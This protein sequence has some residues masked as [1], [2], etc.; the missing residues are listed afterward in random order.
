MG[1]I[2]VTPN[3]LEFGNSNISPICHK[4]QEGRKIFADYRYST[5]KVD[6]YGITIYYNND[7]MQWWKFTKMILL[8][9]GGLLVIGLIVFIIS[10]DNLSQFGANPSGDRL[11]R[12]NN[13]PNYDGEKFV[14]PNKYVEDFT[15]ME[16][17]KMGYQFLFYS[18]AREPS[19]KLPVI[20]IDS[21]A[22][23]DNP[24]NE[25]RVTWMGHSTAFIEI[26]GKRILTDPIWSERNSPSSLWGPKR[27]HPV[28]LPLEKLPPLDAV[29][30]SH[31]HYDHLDKP[32]IESLSKTGVHF[33]VPLGV[34]AHL[35]KWGVALF[36]IHELDWWDEFDL[37]ESS[38]RFLAVPGMHFSGR[39]IPNK[40][41]TLWASWIIM[42]KEQRVFFS[43]DTGEFTGISD[44]GQKYGPF[45]ITLISIGAYGKKWPAIHRTPEQAVA[46]HLALKGKIMIP[47]HW[48]TFNLAFHEWFDPPDRLKKAAEAAQID[49]V[50]P[51]PGQTITESSIPVVETWWREYK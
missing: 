10:T 31:D 42:G 27:F 34:G 20:P 28:P 33:Y 7:I 17:I 22:L 38:V 3:P 11:E 44:I 29:I 51:K 32:T 13:S 12:I 2:F 45:D 50:I 40:N 18:E 6:L 19:F 47:I 25:L 15:F 49:I 41:P 36:Q 4:N 9:F 26:D 1:S 48:G 43:G 30:I 16:S 23:A 35:E 5:L 14:N 24:E 39:R 21:A 46:T 37:P 8:V